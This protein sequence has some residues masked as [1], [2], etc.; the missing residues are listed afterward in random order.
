MTAARLS[1]SMAGSRAVRSL[2]SARGRVSMR[3]RSSPTTRGSRAC[4][5]RAASC[6]Q[7]T[8]P[9]VV[10]T[11]T[12]TPAHV[13]AA[14]DALAELLPRASRRHDGDL[15]AAVRELAAPV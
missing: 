4:P 3:A 2:S 13:L 5:S 12:G 11:G 15:V 8:A 6:A 9:V 7:S 10:L 14:S 1:R